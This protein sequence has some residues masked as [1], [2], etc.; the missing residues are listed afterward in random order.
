MWR[1]A[2]EAKVGHRESSWSLPAGRVKE[3][4]RGGFC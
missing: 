2:G 4:D 1:V 3:R